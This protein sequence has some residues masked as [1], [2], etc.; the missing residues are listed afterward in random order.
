MHI[1][2]LTH[3]F[4][5]EGNAPASRTFEN[6]KRWSA[7][8]HRVT[9]VT[10]VPNVPDGIIYKGYR[11]KLFQRQEI[12]GIRVFRVWTYIAPNRGVFKRGLN[13]FSFMASSLLGIFVIKKA[14][15]VI[16]TSPQ[17]FCGLAGY[18]YSALKRIPFIFE[19]RDLWPEAIIA[20]EALK[21][22]GLIKLLGKIE[23]FL[24]R[25]AKKIIVVTESYKRAISQK[26]IP[27]DKIVVAKNGVDLNYYHPRDRENEV[28]KDLRLNGKYIVSYIGTI[29][30]AQDLDQI[31][32][33]AEYL[34][35]RKN[36]V[37]L[38]VGSGARR[39]SLMRKKESMQLDNVIFIER[40]PKDA[41]PSFY[42]ASDICL[43]TLNRAPL[44]KTV[45]P[46]KIFE[47]MSMARPLILAVDGEARELVELANAGI[48]V[49]PGNHKDLT[50]AIL[51]CY[52]QPQEAEMLGKN[53]RRFVERYSGWDIIANGYLQVLNHSLT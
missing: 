6:C 34:R 2:F 22:R 12:D 19:V 51:R 40:Q 5:P 26:G 11:N 17:F 1:I 24:Y 10:G 33:A 52:S 29:G 47:I 42:A 45:I 31:L 27:Q 50:K 38:F 37:F 8:G 21:N 32:K 49:E 41:I 28:R 18:F 53:G 23:M 35:D 48:F 30:M 15:L 4:P 14:D 39:D 36:I 3:Y 46:S 9:V 16:A 43:A 7:K 44:F 13:Y 25:S 20:T